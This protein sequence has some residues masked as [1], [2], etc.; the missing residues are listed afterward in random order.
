MWVG[1][2]EHSVFQD[3]A[4]S[5]AA[6]GMLAPMFEA[7]FTNLFAALGRAAAPKSL[8]PVAS[9]GFT[10]RRR[11]ADVDYW[12]PH[13]VFDSKGRRA[14]LTA[15]IRQ[16]AVDT[17]LHPLLP[18]D[19]GKVITG[20]FLYRNMMFHNGF[21][22]P[23]ERRGEFAA[24]IKS[25]G[26]PPDWFTHSSR[27]GAP[28]IYYMTQTYVDRCL[29]LVDEVLTAVGKLTKPKATAATGNATKKG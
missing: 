13:I 10:D 1:Q 12:D 19:Y 27:G 26:L 7:L 8:F 11:R 3:A 24:Q 4:N 16:L 14:D 22:W 21:E 18:K 25:Q 5:M 15:G 17:G 20:L 29:T 23:I 28:W 2:M 9:E 6:V